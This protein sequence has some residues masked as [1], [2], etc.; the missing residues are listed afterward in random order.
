[1]VEHVA[2]AFHVASTDLVTVGAGAK[3]LTIAN[4][5]GQIGDRSIR[6]KSA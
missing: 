2:N 5:N 3:A 4:S 6:I 1:M